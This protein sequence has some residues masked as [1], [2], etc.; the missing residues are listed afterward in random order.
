MNFFFDRCISPR[1]A[2]MVA[3]VEEGGLHS[4]THH[5]SLFPRDTPD[6]TWIEFLGRDP[7][8]WAAVSGDGRVLTRKHEEAA[9]RA[10]G[11]RYFIMATGW[12]DMLLPEQAWR[13]LRVWPSVVRAVSELDARVC[14]IPVSRS[15]RIRR[16][17]K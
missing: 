10:A 12:H 17:Q 4:I 7:D 16:L 3:L 15:V 6:V 9:L 8:H 1:I 14:E 13:F 2:Q 5:D 11:F